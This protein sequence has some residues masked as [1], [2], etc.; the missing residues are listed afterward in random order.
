MQAEALVLDVT[1]FII[2]LF[3]AQRVSDVSTSISRSLRLIVDLFHVLY[4]SAPSVQKTI[5][6]L[7]LTFLK[8]QHDPT[9]HKTTPRSNRIYKYDVFII[10][11]MLIR[12]A[13]NK[14]AGN[15]DIPVKQ[16][17]FM[18]VQMQPAARQDDSCAR[19][20]LHSVA[21]HTTGLQQ[22]QQGA[23]S[24]LCAHHTSM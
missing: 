18:A 3:T 22:L 17:L 1:C 2:S 5:W 16:F 6:S 24:P 13:W 11:S 14:Q 19:P 8:K 23:Q 12:R 9:S 15:K 7:M 20:T 21:F 4:C 10:G